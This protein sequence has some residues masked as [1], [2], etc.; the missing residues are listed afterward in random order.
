MSQAPAMPVFTD[1]LIGDTTHLTAAEFG[2]YCL[3]LFVTWR[4][5]GQ[6]LPDDNIRMARVCRMTPAQW[7]KSRPILAAFF[8]LTAGVWRQKRLEKEWN[9]VAKNIEK[10]RENG[11]K[12]GRPKSLKDNETGKAKGSVSP[13]L[14]E[15]THPQPHTQEGLVG[16][17]ACA[18]AC[19]GT[20]PEI[21]PPA[22]APNNPEQAARTVVQKFLEIR[23]ELW[24]AWPNR[25]T[26][27]DT[28]ALQ[29]RNLIEDGAPPHVLIRTIEVEMRD[30]HRS[31][32][33]ATTNPF[34]A[35]RL[36]IASA[37][38]DHR[39]TGGA[40]HAPAAHSTR[41]T[42]R[43]PYDPAESR[44]RTAEGV[45]LAMERAERGG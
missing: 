29:A 19:E 14:N 16:G 13:N 11:S 28:L 10:K 32:Q 20:D 3:I 36:S 15:S 39:T 22:T 1:A 8:D 24:P 26:N 30:A 41:R 33:H 31:G 2:A 12:G 18:P 40:D 7:A 21:T 43:Q 42:R 17:G 38:A 23:D 27:P 25:P 37:I 4:N 45:A 9:Y 6:P 5:N 44:R 35:Y 34:K